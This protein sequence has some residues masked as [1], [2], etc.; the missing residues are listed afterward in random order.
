M[1][2]TFYSSRTYSLLLDFYRTWSNTAVVQ[3]PLF[4]TN[5]WQSAPELAFQ[6][7]IHAD[8]DYAWNLFWI[9]PLGSQGYHWPFGLGKMPA[10][11]LVISFFF[12]RFQM[13]FF[14]GGTSTVPFPCQKCVKLYSKHKLAGT[15]KAAK[16]VDGMILQYL[17]MKNMLIGKTTPHEEH[18]NCQLPED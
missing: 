2:V 16:H 15:W 6:N 18:F 4:Q 9:L 17:Q 10:A 1:G 13:C 7:Q 12:G 3:Y 8:K 11:V 14:F 5:S